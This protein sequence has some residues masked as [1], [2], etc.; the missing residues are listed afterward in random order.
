MSW[1]ELA[2][3]LL[4]ASIWL[5][6]P[7]MVV[8]AA[9]RLPI[10][11]MILA[12]PAVSVSLIGTSAVVGGLLG[13]SFGP[14]VVIAW[15]LALT[16]VALVMPA[17]MTRRGVGWARTRSFPWPYTYSHSALA[18]GASLI[19][20]FVG[21]GVLGWQATAVIG[22]PDSI[23]QSYDAIFHLNAIRYIGDTGNGSTLTLGRMT[24]PDSWLAVYPAA[25]HDFVYLIA[26][27]VD[28]S[29]PAA[30]NAAT[31]G[32]MAIVWPFSAALFALALQ[33][34]SVV[35]LVSAG[36]LSACFTGF[37]TLMLKWGI[38]YPNFLAFALVPAALA[39][40]TFVVHPSRERTRS[41]RLH[42]AFLALLVTA[43]LGLSHLNGLVTLAVLALGLAFDMLLRAT[44]S[45]RS[46]GHWRR[47]AVV[48]AS[49]LVGALVVWRVLNTGANAWGPT[50]TAPRAVGEWVSNSVMG[51]PGG[52]AVSAL[53]L[54]GAYRCISRPLDR[55]LAISWGLTGLLWVVAAGRERDGLSSLLIGSW[56]A[57]P[58]RLGSMTVLMSLPLAVHGVALL[59]D[60]SGSPTLGQ[61]SFRMTTQ[62]WTLAAVILSTTIYLGTQSESMGAA[63]AGTN[64]EFRILSDSLLITED[65]KAVLDRVPELVPPDARIVVDPWEGS[66]LVFAL[67]DRAP[68][69]LHS[70][71]EVPT[72]LRPVL[73]GLKNA[74]SD[75]RVCAALEDAN[76]WFYLGFD[77]TLDIGA[78]FRAMYTG[79]DGVEQRP[80]VV[81]P[82]FTSGDVGLYQ[83][84]GCR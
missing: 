61:P 38:L 25:W 17:L 45:V 56:Y 72:E 66:A 32:V 22:T 31:L 81:R 52:W 43:G 46:G 51:Y 74:E 83:I 27:M 48:G 60:G 75:P 65:E 73:E 14:G 20:A 68:T 11:S 57:D 79:L 77:D 37:P 63:I 34:Q 21:A 76:A 15:T 55:W 30:T 8:T 59:A 53:V 33:G 23:S 5:V 58:H 19:G 62:A 4:V 35:S 13:V 28:V 3:A 16:I 41:A 42:G 47:D 26:S 24:S 2:P 70:L 82:L 50:T 29:I 49:T 67:A 36:T 7:G 12:A 39:A 40:V 69:Q 9:L 80:D 54:V 18:G 44:R 6:A 71:S 64:R 84:V 10:W 1:P 78:D